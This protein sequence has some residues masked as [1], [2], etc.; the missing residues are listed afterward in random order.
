MHAKCAQE[1]LDLIEATPQGGRQK[2]YEVIV[3]H[4]NEA[5]AAKKRKDAAD[6]AAAASAPPPPVESPTPTAETP[7]AVTP[8]PPVL[9]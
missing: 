8:T 4:C 7:P 1:I 9:P 5:I 2:Q 3:A 6:A